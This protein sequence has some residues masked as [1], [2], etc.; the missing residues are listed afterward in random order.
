[1]IRKVLFLFVVMLAA[2]VWAAPRADKIAPGDRIHIT[3]DEETSL[4]RDYK[5][6]NDGFVLVNFL[7]AVK[8]AGLTADEAA[9]TIADRLVSEKI[10]KKATVTVALAGASPKTNA[11]LAPVKFRGVCEAE[12]EL[13][14]H[15]GLGLGELLR[16]AKPRADADLARV[17]I[18]STGG[19][20]RVVDF[21]AYDPATKANDIAL[22]PGDTVTFISKSAGVI[23]K[24]RVEGQVVNPGEYD[25]V[26]GLKVKDFLAK[27]GGFAS[28]AE[29]GYVRLTRVGDADR[30]LKLPQDLETE[31]KPGD[32]LL[33]DKQ[34][35]K[36]VVK[37]DGFVRHAGQVEITEGMTLTEALRAAGGVT[38]DADTSKLRL[39]GPDEEKPRVID[40]GE[41]DRGYMGDLLMRKG[42]RIEV[43][44]K[45]GKVDQRAVRTAAGAAFLLFLVG[46]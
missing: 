13:A 45:K 1:M 2:L 32:I 6:T 39:Y 5:V 4:N 17:S 43:P 35:K 44:D 20:T 22:S 34:L 33:V 21:S 40:V 7:G 27:A 30:K 9:T 36:L 23:G 37:I 41:I 25:L 26:E 46:I 12:G 19:Q 28:E 15:E 29:S 8:V 18:T 31:L 42:M 38:S 24:V 14:F 3:C 10:V 11:T 16:A